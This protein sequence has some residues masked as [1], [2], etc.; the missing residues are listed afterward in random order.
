MGVS[1]CTTSS[2]DL[3]TE[4]QAAAQ[5]EVHP[6]AVLPEQVASLPD[7]RPAQPGDAVLTTAKGDRVATQAQPVQASQQLPMP[8]AA[9]VQSAAL[10]PSAAQPG[11]KVNA[12]AATG[13]N[14]VEQALSAAMAQPRSVPQPAPVMMAAL[15]AQP[16]AQLAQRPQV[17]A[18]TGARVLPRNVDSVFAPEGRFGPTV[19]S[20][21]SPELDKLISQ[22]SSHY[23]V[24]ETLVR[25]V[26]KRES[27]FDPRARNGKY[28]GLMQISHPTARSMG[29]DGPANGLLDA[30]TNLKYAV[31]YLR[32]AWLTAKG[33]QDRA[34][35]FYAR[36]Y[37]FD[38]KRAGLL[39]VTGLGTDR[40]RM[41]PPVP[42]VANAVMPA[43]APVLRG[44]VPQ[45]P[46]TLASQ[47]GLPGVAAEARSARDAIGAVSGGAGGTNG[48]AAFR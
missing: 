27:T 37:Y 19:V 25:R 47:R 28:W 39:D 13:I 35:Q 17:A 40:R 44:T 12:Y 18:A 33:D 41:T 11:L 6:A 43:A 15:S 2:A 3:A 20:A 21:R 46:A 7:A 22:Y 4:L 1:G 30:E 48:T 36:G 31:R 24:P 32:G 9:P 5:A 10:Q 29:Y 34:V 8:V 42:V 23:Q 26:V 45:M 14:P 16:P 38:A